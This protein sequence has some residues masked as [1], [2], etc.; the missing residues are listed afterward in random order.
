MNRDNHYEKAFEWYLRER[1]A[2]VVP[3]VE[4]RRSYLDRDEIKSPDFI[5]VGPH[6]SRLVVDVKGRQFPSLSAGKPRKTW[7]NWSTA[8]DIDGLARWSGRFGGGF[9]GILA[10]IYHVLPSV[11]LPSDT[12]DL[13]TYRERLY[14]A[15]GVEVAEYRE[16]MKARSPKWCTVDL[17][18]ATFRRIVKPF[19]EFLSSPPWA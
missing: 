10:F 7:Q 18:T 9:Q 17:P 14:L 11:Q 8:G 4:A 6:E 13:F 16:H 5:V 2:A 15:R 19:T 1:G 3:I 12:P